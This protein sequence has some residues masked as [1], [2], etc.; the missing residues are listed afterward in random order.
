M[1][2]VLEVGPTGEMARVAGYGITD[3]A[4][5][6]VP[7]N[8]E[9]GF[10]FGCI[11]RKLTNSGDGYSLYVNR[12]NQ[13]SCNFVSFAGAS[14][15]VIALNQEGWKVHDALQTNL[16]GT[17]ASDDLGL[18]SRTFLSGSP[19]IRSV[20]FGG[21]STTAYARRQVA[22]PSDYLAGTDLSLVITAQMEQPADTSSSIDAEVA[23]GDNTDICTTAA[24]VIGTMAGSKTFVLS[25]SSLVPGS[26]LDIRLKFSGVD[27]GDADSG[28]DLVI[29][30]VALNY[31]KH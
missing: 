12:G 29:S 4:L 5:E 20:D 26:I 30:R 21:T 23:L 22:L 8:G 17:A 15:G 31:T 2:E 27:V 16:P 3:I 11:C 1:S 28:I 24:Q 10:A 19:F 25:G 7:A 13:S 18:D 6:S 9:Q 14:A